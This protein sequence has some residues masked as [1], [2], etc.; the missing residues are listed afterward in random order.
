M[1]QHNFDSF[2][3]DIIDIHN[4]IHRDI[5]GDMS[6]TQNAAYDPVFWLHHSYVEKVNEEWKECRR[7]DQDLTWLAE[8]KIDLNKSLR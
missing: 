1:C 8:F 3:S 2:N 5:G 7:R 4:E 6:T